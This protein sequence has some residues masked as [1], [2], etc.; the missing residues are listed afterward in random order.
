MVRD[1]SFQKYSWNSFLLLVIFESDNTIFRSESACLCSPP[2]GSWHTDDLE[3]IGGRQLHHCL[4]YFFSLRKSPSGCN[5]IPWSDVLVHSGCRNKMP[6]A[7]WLKPQTGI[8]SQFWRREVWDEGVS[9]AMIPLRS[10]GKGPPLPLAAPAPCRQ[11]LTTL[12]LKTCHS[13]LHCHL[14]V[15][16]LHLSCFSPSYK[17]INHCI[18]PD[19]TQYDFILT[20]LH[21][22]QLYFPAR[23]H[24]ETA[25][26]R[27][28]TYLLGGGGRHN[29]THN[30]YHTM[31]LLLIF[32]RWRP[33]WGSE[34][35]T[36]SISPS[37]VQ[38][39]PNWVHLGIYYSTN[40]WVSPRIL[41][42]SNTAELES[43]ICAS[44]KD[45]R[46]SQ[47]HLIWGNPK[48]HK[49]HQRFCK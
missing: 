5:R 32:C 33:F 49:S 19:L 39:T 40:S 18:G 48:F 2:V 10:L 3:K 45:H 34:Q 11:F 24:S 38:Q 41:Q 22:Q 46:W 43:R 23:S 36:V 30:G 37:L 15:A 4:G 27:I 14:H 47:A 16:A 6:Q 26:V 35:V 29:S 20:W 13:N 9:G 8:F 17:D 28:W 31:R 42:N 21:L 44:H 1:R 7:G 25:G 12:G